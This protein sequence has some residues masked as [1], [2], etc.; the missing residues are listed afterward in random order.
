MS[1]TKYRINTS[2]QRH[3]STPAEVNEGKDYTQPGQAMSPQEIMARFASGRPVPQNEPYY[4]DDD[5]IDPKTLDIYELHE[6]RR[7]NMEYIQDLEQEI[8]TRT[9]KKPSSTA[10]QQRAKSDE[11]AKRSDNG[12]PISSD[13]APA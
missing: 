11:P 2:L 3:Y 4:S 9:G 12:D 6:L 7:E 8:K 13:G 5:F 1:A 10:E